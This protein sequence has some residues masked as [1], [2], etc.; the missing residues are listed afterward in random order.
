V[1]DAVYNEYYYLRG[2]DLLRLKTNGDFISLYPGVNSARVINA[3]SAMG[4]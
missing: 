3:I 4:G 1:F 2:N